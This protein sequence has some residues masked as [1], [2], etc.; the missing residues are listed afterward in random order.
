MQTLADV[1]TAADE[2]LYPRHVLQGCETALV[3][4]A[5]AFMGRQDAVWVAEAGLTATCVDH[6]ARLLRRM[7]RMYPAGWEF[8]CGDAYEFAEESGGQ[9]DVVSVDCPT[10]QFERCAALLPTW[11]D[12]ARRAVVLGTGPEGAGLVPPGGWVLTEWLRRSDFVEGGV[13]WAVIARQP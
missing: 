11:C 2:S 3:V 8:V 1:R 6:D 7:E 12:L 10:G 5:A 4:F 9:W 13:Y